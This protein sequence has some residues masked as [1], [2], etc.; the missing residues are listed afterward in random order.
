[1]PKTYEARDRDGKPVYRLL[2]V[3]AR[4]DRGVPVYGWPTGGFLD[5]LDVKAG[6]YT[7]H[8]SAEAFG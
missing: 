3:I 8:E 1:M 4:T 5:P 2:Q 6:K 7:I